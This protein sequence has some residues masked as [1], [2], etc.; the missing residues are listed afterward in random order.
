M[1]WSRLFIPTLREGERLLERAGYLRERSYLFLGLRSRRK[2]ERIVRE[3]LDSI[4][5]Q[6]MGVFESQAIVALA[7]A[8][9]S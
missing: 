8:L 9:R 7:R 6:E 3:E 1:Y 5:A 4:G 2:I